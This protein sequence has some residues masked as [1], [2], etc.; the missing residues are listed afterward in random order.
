MSIFLKVFSILLTLS[1]TL[2]CGSRLTF[3]SEHVKKTC[4]ACFLQM[5]DLCRIRLY[6]TQ[7]VA[8]LAAHAL[9]SSRLD[10]C[11]SLFRGL[12]C[13][14]QNKLQSIQSTLAHIV[15]NQR[16]Y[17]HVTSIFKRF[18]WFP[19]NY[20]CMFK[21]QH[22]FINFYTMVLLAILEHPCLLAVALTVPGI[23]ILIVNI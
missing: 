15:T 12:S 23:F 4:I 1:N 5:C 14:N 9:V 6:V 10:Y 17:N 7:E 18:H 20:R 19:V 21:M 3:F 8:V 2:V 11:N 22:W 16:K 13:F